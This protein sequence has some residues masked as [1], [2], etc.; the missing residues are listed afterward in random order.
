MV[1]H[2]IYV[3]YINLCCFF[4]NPHGKIIETVFFLI[5]PSENFPQ[6]KKKKSSHSAYSITSGQFA[7]HQEGKTFFGGKPT[8]VIVLWN[9]KSFSFFVL[10]LKL[11]RNFPLFSIC[12]IMQKLRLGRQ[13]R[14]EANN[15]AMFKFTDY[16]VFFFQDFSGLLFR[17]TMRCTV[18]V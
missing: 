11:F 6:Q 14:F 3:R 17:T 9:S 10:T 4:T 15:Y 8:F 12:L 18:Q 13:L 5:S 16:I 7:W 1:F 2:N